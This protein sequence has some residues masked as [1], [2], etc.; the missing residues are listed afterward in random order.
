VPFS[1][2][3]SGTWSVG[4]NSA[5]GSASPANAFYIGMNSSSNNLVGL[6]SAASSS[7]GTSGDSVLAVETFT[8]NGTNQDR[9]RGNENTTLLAS[10]ARTT[11]QASAD[12]VNYNGLTYLD[13]ILDT[14]VA[15]TGS[16]TL[17]IDGKDPASGKY[18]NLLTGAAVTTV[19]TNVYRVGVGLTP[20]ANATANMALPRT[21]RIVVTA[22]NAN[23]QT[24]SVG[25]I[26]MRS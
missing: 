11:T 23:T 18:Y 21:F 22:N 9:K 25:Y 14:T 24:Y 4:A 5:T 13:V 3:Q 12:I 20:T 16:V 26:M 15:S 19:S 10:A 2:S 7:D 6:R 8:F 1:V 17:S